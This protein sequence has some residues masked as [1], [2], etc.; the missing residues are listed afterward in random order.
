MKKPWPAVVL[1]GALVFALAGCGGK[2]EPKK[3]VADVKTLIEN[4][5]STCH[6]SNRIFD[7]PRPAAQWTDIIQRMRAFN[8]DMLSRE[9]VKRIVAYLEKHNSRPEESSDKSPTLTEE[10]LKLLEEDIDFPQ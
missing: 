4:K 8:Q 3:S 1:G 7:T 6:F 5:C 9:E 2:G 10:E